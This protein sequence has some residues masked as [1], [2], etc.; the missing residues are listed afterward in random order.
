[1]RKAKW[2]VERW[3][4]LLERM[5]EEDAAGKKFRRPMARVAFIEGKIEEWEEYITTCIYGEPEPGT[6]W[7]LF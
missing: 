7:C 2:S 1:M 6:G 5:A 4:K 3:Y